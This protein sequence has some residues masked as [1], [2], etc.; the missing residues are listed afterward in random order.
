MLETLIPDGEEPMPFTEHFGASPHEVVMEAADNVIASVQK[1]V[2]I[3]SKFKNKAVVNQLYNNGIFELKDAVKIVAAR[4]G[5]TTPS[6]NICV[7]VSP[8]RLNTFLCA[9]I[10]AAPGSFFPS[11]PLPVPV[12]FVNGKPGAHSLRFI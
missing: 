10:M 8:A 4:L 9:A 5:I 3:T 1:D 7:N 11:L 12:Y 2:M 6:T